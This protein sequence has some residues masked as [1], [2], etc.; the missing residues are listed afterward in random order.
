MKGVTPWL[1]RWA[2]RAGIRDFI[3]PWPVQ[4][5]FFLTVHYLNLCVRIAQQPGHAGSRAGPPVSE[6]LSAGLFL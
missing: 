1:V 5:N 6:C 2:R 3:L 4:N